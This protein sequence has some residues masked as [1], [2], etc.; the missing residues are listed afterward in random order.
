MDWEN[1]SCPECKEPIQEEGQ[2][3]CSYCK[4]LFDWEDEE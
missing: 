3:R 2:T 1:F 4:V